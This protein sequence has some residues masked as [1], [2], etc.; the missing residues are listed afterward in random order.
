[1]QAIENNKY[2]IIEGAKQLGYPI[3]A[4]EA[5]QFLSYLKILKHWNSRINLTAIQD[6]RGIII[7]HFLDSLAG[8]TALPVEKPTSPRNVSLEISY[9]LMDVGT[10][11]G[12]PGLPLKICRPQILLALVEPKKKKAAFLHSICG[13]LGLK[14]VN[15]LT[16]LLETIVQQAQHQGAYD[17]VIS[18]ALRPL[19]LLGPA[20]SLLRP[21]GRVVLWTSQRNESLLEEIKDLPGWGQPEAISYQL[22]FEDLERNLILLVKPKNSL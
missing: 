19:K 3:S 7:R 14:G 13:Q 21:G 6:D 12:F 20:S 17:F 4:K 2:L 10:G 18:R 5:S 1:M 11:A 9:R 8:L 22:P 16:Q 15:I